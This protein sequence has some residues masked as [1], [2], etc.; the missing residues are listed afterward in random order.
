MQFRTV[1]VNPVEIVSGNFDATWVKPGIYDQFNRTRDNATIKTKISAVDSLN[2]GIIVRVVNLVFGSIDRNPKWIRITG[3]YR[4]RVQDQTQI[5]PVNINTANSIWYEGCAVVVC[6][7]GKAKVNVFIPVDNGIQPQRND[8]EIFNLRI[9]EGIHNHHHRFFTRRDGD[10]PL[11]V[12]DVSW[13]QV[14]ARG[15]GQLVVRDQMILDR[16]IQ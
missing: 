3:H 10:F 4:V 7:V 8:F 15:G 14:N 13:R 2:P 5:C 1:F 12:N 9:V 6:E 16:H 11:T